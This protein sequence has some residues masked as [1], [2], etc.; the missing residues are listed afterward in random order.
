LRLDTPLGRWAVGSE[1]WREA[2]LG[3]L[4]LLAVTTDTL[5]SRRLA[6]LRAKKSKEAAK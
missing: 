1:F 4:I 3:P 6:K 2:V 5:L